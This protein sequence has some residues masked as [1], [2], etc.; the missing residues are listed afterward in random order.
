MKWFSRI[1]QFFKKGTLRRTL[2]FYLLIACLIPPAMLAGYTYSSMHS[3]LKHKISAGI[4][5]SLRQEATGIENLLSNLDFVSK[6]FALDGQTAARV[7]EYMSSTS[8][9]EKVAM[10]EQIE[11]TFN[12]VNFTAGN[13]GAQMGGW[14]K[15]EIKSVSDLILRRSCRQRKRLLPIC[16]LKVLPRMRLLSRLTSNGV[17]FA[18]RFTGGM[19]SMS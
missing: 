14:F 5:A 3:I 2:I 11:A 15:R 7:N 6:Q 8:L 13:S 1:R 10:I 12:V 16:Y 17:R 4:E 9:S 19:R 18:P